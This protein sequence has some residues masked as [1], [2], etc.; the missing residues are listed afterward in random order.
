MVNER[1]IWHNCNAE[2]FQRVLKLQKRTARGLFRRRKDGTFN[3]CIN[4]NP[5]DQGDNVVHKLINSAY[6]TPGYLNSLLV[7]NSENSFVYH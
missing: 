4:F 5:F 2:C 6:N 3:C 1:V 7:Q